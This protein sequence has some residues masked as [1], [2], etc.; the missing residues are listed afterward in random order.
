M[1]GVR[2][3]VVSLLLFGILMVALI[4]AGIYMASEN[5]SNNTIGNE[6]AIK[7]YYNSLN[8]T[9]SDTKSVANE[10]EVNIG[11]SDMSILQG[12]VFLNTL[13]TLWKNIVALPKAIFNA[14]AVFIT[15]Y[16]FPDATARLI[17]GVLG[18]IIVITIVIFVVK[19][20]TTGEG[21]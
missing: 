3:I 17:I 14:T 11:D 4:T 20:I 1:A 10:S 18:G 8:D 13:R 2:G 12:V 5:N 9:L 16:L 21:G 15:E 19:W 7:E 6:P